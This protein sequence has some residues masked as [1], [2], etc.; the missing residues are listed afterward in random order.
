MSKITN[1]KEIE[2]PPLNESW[3]LRKCFLQIR[4]LTEQLFPSISKRSII[5]HYLP[6]SGALSHSVFTAHI[7][8]PQIVTR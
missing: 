7:F 8:A 5:R 3:N 2:S 1:I 6:L 4:D